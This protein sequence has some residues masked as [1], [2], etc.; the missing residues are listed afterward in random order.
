MSIIA[1]PETI[2]KL[3][4]SRPDVKIFV[5]YLDERLNE[6]GYT[7]GFGDAGDRLFGAK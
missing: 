3:A 7:R 5:A 1:A 4:E 6:N 2:E